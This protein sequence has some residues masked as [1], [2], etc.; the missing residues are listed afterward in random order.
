MRHRLTGDDDSAIVYTFSGNNTLV[1]V[2]YQYDPNGQ[3]PSVEIYG[4][5]GANYANT[6]GGSKR[7]NL[8]RRSDVWD[9]G[10]PKTVVMNKT[11]SVQNVQCDGD[12]NFTVTTLDAN[13]KTLNFTGTNNLDA[14]VPTA[15]PANVTVTNSLWPSALAILQ[16]NGIEPVSVAFGSG[17]GELLLC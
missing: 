17:N 15:L 2:T 12:M 4:T 6:N 5:L 13:G 3:G 1:D 10:S 11:V 16:Y 14:P 9:N 7:R 8:F